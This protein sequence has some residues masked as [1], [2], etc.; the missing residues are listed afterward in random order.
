MIQGSL[1]ATIFFIISIIS[2]CFTSAF[3]QPIDPVTRGIDTD[4]V[5]NTSALLPVGILIMKSGF[6]ADI[7]T[8]YSRAF[9]MARQ[10][11]PDS[12]IQPVIMDA[13]SNASVASVTWNL[14]KNT[15]PDLP[16]VVTVASWTTNVVY[17][18]A[19]RSGTIQVALGSAIVNRSQPSDH[20]I[21]FTPGGDQEAPAL[22]SYLQKF[23]R[24]AV[25]GG[26]NDYTNGYFSALDTLLPGKIQ[27]KSYYNPDKPDDTLNT[28]AIRES[29]PEVIVLLS[30]S[31]GGKIAQILRAAGISVQ[32]AGTRIIEG[33]TLAKTDAAEGLVFTT[34]ALNQSHPFFQRYY[35]DFGVNATFF[36]AEG[37]DAMTT[38]YAAASDHNG[39]TDGL[40]SHFTNQTYT[41]ALGTVRF[42][43]TGVASYPITLKIVHSGKFED[44]SSS[45]PL[46]MS[47]IQGI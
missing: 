15:T 3:A 46:L 4:P 26:N 2:I 35:D 32:L 8:E 16:I 14:M 45:S 40:Y 47:D 37:Y 25:I 13:G 11:N 34:P 31:E 42:N 17:P 7:G 24:I 29:N 12:R 21:R 23:N 41:G 43:N 30:A 38:L 33:A 27:L 1:I 28:T 19:A 44:I 5:R 9:D 10:D 20:L 39:S 18:D 36:G 6:V 22:A